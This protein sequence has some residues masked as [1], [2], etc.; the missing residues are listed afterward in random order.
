MNYEIL[1]SDGRIPDTDTARVEHA[2]IRPADGRPDIA[3][4][5]VTYT[6]WAMRKF[7]VPWDERMD[8]VRSLLPAP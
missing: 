2:R 4:I 3:H 5:E 7:R 6:N 8:F 1:P